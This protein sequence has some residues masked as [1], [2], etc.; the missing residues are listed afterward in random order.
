[1]LLELIQIRPPLQIKADHLVSSLGRRL[2]GVNQNQQASDDRH[3]SLDL[4]P[5][6]F[7][8]EQVAAVQHRFDR[9]EKQFD[10][11][12]QTIEFAD[13]LRRYI[14]KVRC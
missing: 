5:V 8:A 4:D 1:M 11:P 14:K 13:Q 6:L 10:H 3:I 9:A 7:G 2:A 12:T